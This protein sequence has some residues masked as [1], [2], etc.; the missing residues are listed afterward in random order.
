MITL[1]TGLPGHGKTLFTLYEINKQWAGKRPIYYLSKEAVDEVAAGIAGVQLEGWTAFTEF[2]KWWDIENGAVIVVDE[3]QYVLPRRSP[4]KEPEY[5]SAFAEHRKKGFDIFLITQDCR[6]MDY[7]VRRLAGQHI[8]Y[9]RPMGASAASRW[10]WA[11]AC[12]NPSDRLEQKQAHSTKLVKHPKDFY[13][14]YASA[15]V[16]TV[17]RKI[18]PKLFIFPVALVITGVLLYFGIT[19]LTKKPENKTATTDQ[20]KTTESSDSAKTSIFPTKASDKPDLPNVPPPK[21][22]KVTLSAW[23]AEGI[24]IEDLPYIPPS[25][26]TTRKIVKCPQ[27]VLPPDTFHLFRNRFCT[28]DDNDQPQ[29]C[30]VYVP[31]FT[32]PESTV[33]AQKDSSILPL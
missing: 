30:Y 21:P 10:E 22:Y 11:K 31:I 3:C 23:I 16:H 9:H 14:K 26:T 24:H 17:Q 8:H 7:F 28:I 6:N 33:T 19:N 27:H 15:N 2:Q 1:V 20:A 29:N 5:I 4:G 32:P 25:C 12:E 18:P 13:D